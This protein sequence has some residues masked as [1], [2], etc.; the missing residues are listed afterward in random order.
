MALTRCAV[1]HLYDSERYASCPYC[2]SNQRVIEFDQGVQPILSDP[3]SGVIRPV[4]Q[5]VPV[6]AAR[7]TQAPLGY[8]GGRQEIPVTGA[9]KTQAPP[10]Y[11]GGQREVSVTDRGRTMPPPDWGRQERRVTDPNKTQSEMTT[12]SGVEPVVGWLVCVEGKEKGRSFQLYGRINTI[13]R[14]RKNDI[15]FSEDTLVSREDDTRVGY[16]PRSNSF[17]VIPSQNTNN[18]YLNG[19]VIDASTVIRAYDILEIGGEKLVFI[20]LCS[21]RFSWEKG[22][23]PAQTGGDGYGVV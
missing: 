20:P 13:G 12:D 15:V 19:S 5:E 21:E 8:G 23:I 7:E 10:G 14:G 17:R 9:Q 11:G 1:G 18:I 4:R 16:D 22:V 2:N 3:V 6:T